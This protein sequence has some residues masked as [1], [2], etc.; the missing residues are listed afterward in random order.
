MGITITLAN[1]TELFQTLRQPPVI[2]NHLSTT[3]DGD[4]AGLRKL[5]LSHYTGDVLSNVASCDCGNNK[6]MGNHNIGLHCNVC[7]TEVIARGYDELAPTVWFKRPE[8]VEALINPTVFGMLLN[9]FKVGKLNMVEYYVSPSTTLK[10]VKSIPSDVQA[11]IAKDFPRG[12]NSFVANFHA[13]VGDLFSLKTFNSKA[14]NRENDDALLALLEMQPDCIFSDY[15]PIPN[16]ALLVL[17]NTNSGPI[18]DQLIVGAVDAI[19][20]MTGIDSPDNGLTVRVKQNKTA[21]AIT[22]LS[23]YYKEFV[24][25]YIAKDIGLCRQYIVATRCNFSFRTV[26][27][28]GTKPGKYNH[29]IIPWDIACTLFRLHLVNKLFKRG[30]TQNEAL[31]F[32]D[33]NCRRYNLFMDQLLTE[34]IEESPEKGIP[35]IFLRN[36]TMP[37]ASIQKMLIAGF[38]RDPD[39][40]TTEFPIL[41]VKGPNADFDGKHHCRR[42]TR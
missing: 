7:G 34:L 25:N 2:L 35:C 17:E 37:R 12:Y 16:K 26:I 22:L 33:Q 8:G 10:G 15:L 5:V 18:A 9:R 29:I 14:R 3:G 4:Y 38:K 1:H 36:P 40:P 21:R 13:I 11:H 39:D 27:S 24:R 42:L 41:S 31:A 28:S 32:I 23:N 20:T 19:F 6:I 30:Y